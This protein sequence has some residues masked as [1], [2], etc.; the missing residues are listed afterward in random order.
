MMDWY[1]DGVSGLD[2]FLHFETDGSVSLHVRQG[3]PLEAKKF[4]ATG[5]L[6]TD[7]DA[8]LYTLHFIHGGTSTIYFDDAVGH[9][10]VFTTGG[11][12]TDVG[13][14]KAMVLNRSLNGQYGYLMIGNGA[15]PSGLI[16][17]TYAGL[18]ATGQL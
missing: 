12:G 4:S 18:V 14:P 3:T 16:D 2:N 6:P 13:S 9:A 5:I 10:F 1:L 7:G 15:L 8:H 11:F 17:R